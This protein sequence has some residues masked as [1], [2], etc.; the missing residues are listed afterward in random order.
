MS[1]TDTLRPKQVYES[2]GV[3]SQTLRRWAAL[4]KD[5]LSEGAQ[6]GLKRRA[7]TSGDVAMLRLAG[8]LV[9]QGVDTN[10]IYARL[11]Q[12]E[13]PEDLEATGLILSPEVARELADTKTIAAQLTEIVR[14]YGERVQALEASDAEKSQLIVELAAEREVLRGEVERLKEIDEVERREI[15]KLILWRRAYERRPWLMRLLS[16][17][18]KKE[19]E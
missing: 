14:V 9:N 17:G 7:Y 5:Y 19:G 11:E 2:L 13:Q 10:E 3:S 4:F 6:P 12:Q 16:I 1:L 15:R 18:L 8:L